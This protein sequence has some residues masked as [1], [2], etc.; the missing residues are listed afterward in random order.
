M[1]VTRSVIQFN[2]KPGQRDR[3]LEHFVRTGVLETSSFQAGYLGAQLMSSTS[4]P[5]IAI[6]IADW[7]SP[8][9][10]QGW[11]DNPE[12]ERV[13]NPL[14][15]YLDPSPEGQSFTLVHAVSPQTPAPDAD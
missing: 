14:D 4:E 8:E 6:V 3:F 9:A 12:R 11:L 1:S 15:Q 13:G 5:D 2:I 7:E 10:Y